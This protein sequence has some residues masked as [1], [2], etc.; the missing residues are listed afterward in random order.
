MTGKCVVF[1]LNESYA[2]SLDLSDLEEALVPS[3]DV[4]EFLAVNVRGQIL[5]KQDMVG[6]ILHCVIWH[7]SL[8]IS[9]R[10]NR[11]ELRGEPSLLTHSHLVP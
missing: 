11:S 6:L 8:R 3:K 1:K 9:L 2:L 4:M 5:H 10:L 7:V